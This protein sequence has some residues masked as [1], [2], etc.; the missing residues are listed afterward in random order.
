MA[1]ELFWGLAQIGSRHAVFTTLS[2]LP[3]LSAD[4]VLHQKLCIIESLALPLVLTYYFLFEPKL[5]TGQF[6]Y[7]DA[8][9]GKWIAET[10]QSTSR[11]THIQKHGT[12]KI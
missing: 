5:R 7:R 6:P 11:D 1:N 2:L 10:M 4:R 8:Q 12:G 3:N 9:Q